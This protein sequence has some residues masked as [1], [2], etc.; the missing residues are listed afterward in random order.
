MVAAL[1]RVSSCRIQD[2]DG[3]GMPSERSSPLDRSA[4]EKVADPSTWATLVILICCFL[5]VIY[6]PRPLLHSIHS[7]WPASSR[8]QRDGARALNALWR[9]PCHGQ[10]YTRRSETSV[11]FRVRTETKAEHLKGLRRS[12][13]SFDGLDARTNAS[14]YHRK[15]L[16]CRKG[17]RPTSRTA[18]YAWANAC[19]TTPADSATAARTLYVKERPITSEYEVSRAHSYTER[20]GPLT[21]S[22]KRRADFE[23]RT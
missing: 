8:L 11:W 6:T 7:S 2:H 22:R 18:I 20:T 12:P 10:R 21:T 23:T 3:R 1:R 13:S 16:A 19:L 5:A 15:P 17:R 4:I 14:A 9:G